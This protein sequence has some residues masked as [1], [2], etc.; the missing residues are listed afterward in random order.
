MGFKDLF[1]EKEET[2]EE[3]IDLGTLAAGVGEYSAEPEVEVAE[4]NEDSTDIIAETY[5]KNNLTDLGNSIF[6]VEELS[7]TLPK[8]MVTETKRATVASIMQTVGL[9]VEA[10]V[11]DASTRSFILGETLGNLSKK[12]SE[13]NSEAEAKIEEL[14]KAIAENEALIANNKETIKTST[15][16]IN[17][18][19][20]RI[21]NLVKFIKG[22]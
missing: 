15:E 20:E 21:N 9:S 13:E 1:I 11:D 16:K 19:V 10:A 8:E 5:E 12:L 4:V 17:A 22:E 3:E 6:K 2:E 7:N 14:K 18:E